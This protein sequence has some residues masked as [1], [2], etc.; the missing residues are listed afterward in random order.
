MA[1][2]A[3][4]PT[5]AHDV[6]ALVL[7]IAL[8]VAAAFALFGFV[9]GVYRVGDVGMSPGV[10]DGDLVMYYRLD[11]S[12]AAG[13]VVVLN[14]EGAP[15]AARIIAVGGDEVNIDSQGLRVNGSYQQ[16][17]DIR[18]ETTQVAG[19]VTFP[20]T[21]PEGSVFLI[22]DNRTGAVD[23]RIYGC[24]LEQDILGKVMAQFRRRGF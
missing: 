11:R 24:V 15:T 20:L 7:K 6:L 22:G 8:I 5:L 16:E 17:R 23:S 3:R 18:E 4:Q 2:E 9:F 10:K 21:V 19:G 1:E 13:E 12:F 14:Y